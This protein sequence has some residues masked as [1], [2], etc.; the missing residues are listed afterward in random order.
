MYTNQTLENLS[1]AV[2]SHISIST[3]AE[4]NHLTISGAQFNGGE[5]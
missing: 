4:S 5:L 2:M 1:I 3:N